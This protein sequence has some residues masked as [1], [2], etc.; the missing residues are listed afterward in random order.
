MDL[1]LLPQS[2]RDIVSALGVSDAITVLSTLAGT[3]WEVPLFDR[4]H[5]KAGSQ[6][7]RYLGEPLAMR[8]MAAFGGETLIVPR[9]QKAINGVRD[10]AIITGF[11]ELCRDGMS[12]RLALSELALQYRLTTVSIWNIVNRVA[13]AKQDD[14]QLP[15]F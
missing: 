13:A 14:S 3:R 8:L 7:V 5:N 6:L 4:R 1:D 9:C 11:E 2:A 10:Q 12:V 15:L